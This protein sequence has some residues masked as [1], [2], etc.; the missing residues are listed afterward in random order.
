[1]YICQICLKQYS[2][3]DK[4][5]KH[6]EQCVEERRSS[7]RRSSFKNQRSPR[8]ELPESRSSSIR[9]NICTTKQKF[10]SLDNLEKDD[11]QNSLY[12]SRSR[13]SNYSRDSN[14]SSV[15]SHRDVPK[16][17]NTP[18]IRNSPRTDIPRT[19]IP[20]TD[21]P[22][23]EI[24]PMQRNEIVPTRITTFV[25]NQD[26]I[27]KAKK[28]HTEIKAKYQ[29]VLDD[30]K[31]KD[32]KISLL[33]KEMASLQKEII[34]KNKLNEEYKLKSQ[35]MAEIFKNTILKQK[36]EYVSSLPIKIEEIKVLQEAFKQLS[37]KN[38]KLE[39]E[40]HDSVLL[41]SQFSAVLNSMTGK[42]ENEIHILKQE[43]IALK[44]K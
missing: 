23:R 6:V 16:I 24:E 25:D 27:N 8:R 26:I 10:A 37:E 42:Y 36:E 2:Y 35:K 11:D 31:K 12:E 1:M 40:K 34:E 32:E 7:T 4:F 44:E 21:I 5:D 9:G 30:N 38:A 28:F 41:R 22:R 20:R 43:I 14:S 17:R 13:D 29:E 15:S 19:D 39:Q 33:E 18:E 3:K